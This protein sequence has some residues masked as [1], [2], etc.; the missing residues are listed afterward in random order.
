MLSGETGQKKM[1][2]KNCRTVVSKVL[3]YLGSGVF[4]GRSNGIIPGTD[5]ADSKADF[6]MIMEDK[7]NLA[8]VC[9]IGWQMQKRQPTI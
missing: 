6:R 3:V 5:S 2:I 4:F 7:G 8:F 1:N 9:I